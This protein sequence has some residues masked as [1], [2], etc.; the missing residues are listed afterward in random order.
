MSFSNQLLTYHKN[1]FSSN[2]LEVIR[3]YFNTFLNRLSEND[4]T[5]M[6]INNIPHSDQ[7]STNES[8]QSGFDALEEKS[9]TC[10]DSLLA[11]AYL[12]YEAYVSETS[13][14]SNYICNFLEY[15]KKNAQTILRSEIYYNKAFMEQFKILN[16][17]E[18]V[19][20]LFLLNGLD[21]IILS[22]GSPH[23]SHPNEPLY[24][25]LKVNEI[26]EKALALLKEMCVKKKIRD[27]IHYSK[28]IREK[29]IDKDY[30]NVYI[31]ILANKVY[32]N[33]EKWL[34]AYLRIDFIHEK[35]QH[36]QNISYSTDERTIIFQEVVGIDDFYLKFQ[37]DHSIYENGDF[38]FY[39]HDDLVLPANYEDY[40]AR[41]NTNHYQF[42]HIQC[43]EG[44]NLIFSDILYS[45]TPINYSK[46]IIEKD[47]IYSGEIIYG[48]KILEDIF[49]YKYGPPVPSILIVFPLKPFVFDPHDGIKNSKNY[50]K[51]QW[52]IGEKLRKLV[53]LKCNKGEENSPEIIESPFTIEIDE[54]FKGDV[55]FG[56]FWSG[57]DDLLEKQ[58]YLFIKRFPYYKN[59][60]SF[61]NQ[62]R[63]EEIVL[64]ENKVKSFT[65]TELEN[66][67]NNI[68]NEKELR[69]EVLIPILRDLG[70]DN[71]KETHG[72]REFGKDIVFTIRDKFGLPEWNVMVVKNQDIHGD[73]SKPNNFALN[74]LSELKLCK[75]MPYKDL[76]YGEKHFAKV[77]LVINGKFRDNAIDIISKNL[78]DYNLNGCLYFMDR[79]FLLNL[80]RE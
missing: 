49:G 13:K 76:N 68:T 48:L 16:N 6:Y 32:E 64:I 12:Y 46:E 53:Y 26:T 25:N 8:L 52:E 60:I 79:E 37:N 41:I 66:K 10:G 47:Y 36:I 38:H 55:V 78:K 74:V 65:Q 80:C 15:F 43:P 59:E 11:R 44:I 31:K 27:F 72:T 45:T 23:P 71:V 3:V 17:K 67:L 58:T 33:Q 51:I 24:G 62:S 54:K 42:R 19:F 77:Y 5:L 63:P 61:I 40:K 35:E 75:A 73:T 56:I 57:K 7:I 70:Y 29:Y 30:S 14:Y 34:I 20:L 18:I 4:N 69:R 1:D 22:W 9:L 50:L 28:K 21:F 39:F 2:E